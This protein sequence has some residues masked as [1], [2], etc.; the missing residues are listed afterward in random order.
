MGDYRKR[1]LMNKDAITTL[2]LFMF[3]R[4]KRQEIKNDKGE[5]RT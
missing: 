5:T 3:I 4:L 2:R 1:Q